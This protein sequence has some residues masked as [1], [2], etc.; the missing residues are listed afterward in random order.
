MGGPWREKLK[1]LIGDG[2][3]RGE[4]PKALVRNGRPLAREAQGAHR[5]GS[6]R[7]EKLKALIRDGSPRAEINLKNSAVSKIRVVSFHVTGDPT[8]KRNSATSK[9]PR[10][11]PLR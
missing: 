10:R 6:P 2:S 5:G 9:L 8:V 4:K 3:P 1:A 7:G 11:K